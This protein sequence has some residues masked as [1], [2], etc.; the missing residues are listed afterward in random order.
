MYIRDESLGEAE[1]GHL[2]V[3]EQCAEVNFPN[4][5]LEGADGTN[6]LE[7]TMELS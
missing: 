5:W 1:E 3:Y 4:G 7:G 2:G 6:G